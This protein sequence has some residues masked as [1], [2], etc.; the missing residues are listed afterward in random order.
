MIMGMPFDFQAAASATEKAL[1][2]RQLSSVEFVQDYLQLRFDGP[3][4]TALA[5]P[6]VAYDCKVLRWGDPGYRDSICALIANRVSRVYFANENRTFVIGFEGNRVLE[7]W[8]ED[9]KPVLPET[10]MFNDPDGEWWAI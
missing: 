7:I 9:N 8:A 1:H 10:I 3:Y 6:R 4:V 2:G 5:W